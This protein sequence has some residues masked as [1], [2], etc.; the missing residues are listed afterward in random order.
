MEIKGIKKISLIANT[1]ILFLVFGLSAFFL[2][3]KVPFLLAFSILTVCVYLVG[4]YCKKNRKKR[5]VS[6][7]VT[8]EHN[9]DR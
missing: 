4:Y 9:T 7:E 8:Y 5:V 1:V 6:E 3:V 2:F